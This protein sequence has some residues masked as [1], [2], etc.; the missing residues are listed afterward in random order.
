MIRIVYVFKIS[1][2]FRFGKEKTYCDRG[3]SIATCENQCGPLRRGV[4]KLKR[5]ETMYEIT[6]ETSEASR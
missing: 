1:T 2:T 3:V 5:T 4:K 6:R